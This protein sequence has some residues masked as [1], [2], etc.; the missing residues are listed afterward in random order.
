M[1]PGLTIGS[2]FSIDCWFRMI[3]VSNSCAMG[4][5]IFRSERITVTLAVPPRISGPYEGIHVTS[6][7][8]ITPE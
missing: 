1:P 3:A 4:D 8:C 5:E 2:N 6:K 7:S